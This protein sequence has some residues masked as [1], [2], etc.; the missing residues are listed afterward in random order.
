M[1]PIAENEWVT[2]QITLD[3]NGV[4]IDMSVTV[5]SIPVKPQRMLPIFQ[6]M[7]NSFVEMGVT[8]AAFEGRQVSCTKGCGACCSQPV[9]VAE[10]EAYQ[11]AELVENLPEPRR[12]E[13]KGRFE[14]SFAHFAE[15][16][17]F[18]RLS[19]CAGG[20]KEEQEA[21]VLDYFRENISCPFLVEGACSI[22]KDRPLACREYLVSSPAENCSNP[23]AE[24]IDMIKPPVKP[25]KTLLN[26][27]QKRQITGVNFIPLVMSL[28]WAQSNE[29]KFDEK[30]G[31]QWLSEFFQKLTGKEIPGAE[32]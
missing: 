14:E 30:T 19:E 3:I 28:R 31:E 16:G 22:H 9:P 11:L 29:E 8:S 27:G 10:I 5:P 6:Q 15:I 4:P 7:T 26:V 12:S 21:V 2:G 18:D 13:I 20:T 23:T 24:S 1:K 25:S 32:T 17:W